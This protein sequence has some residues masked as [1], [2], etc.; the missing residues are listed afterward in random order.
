MSPNHEI[1]ARPL[2]SWRMCVTSN[3]VGNKDQD[4]VGA[5]DS[6]DDDDSDEDDDDDDDD[7][8]E[9]NDIG[10]EDDDDDNDEDDK[11]LGHG[12][13]YRGCFSVKAWMS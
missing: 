10:D 2:A 7:A 12:V 6:S 1:A 11:S 13:A 9:D 8:G 5:S 4:V 3:D